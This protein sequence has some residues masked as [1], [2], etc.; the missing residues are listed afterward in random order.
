MSNQHEGVCRFVGSKQCV[1]RSCALTYICAR[2]LRDSA[3]LTGNQ[4]EEICRS[5]DY[6][7]IHIEGTSMAM[8][9]TKWWRALNSPSQ[10][11]VPQHTYVDVVWPN[12]PSCWTGPHDHG[13]C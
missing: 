11:P 13:A 10:P 8:A 6:E 3:A 7:G 12:N 2:I 5:E 4:H 9:L 1:V